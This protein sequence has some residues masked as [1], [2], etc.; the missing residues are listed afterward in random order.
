MFCL[1]LYNEWKIIQLI[2]M[3]L[4]VEALA[5]LICINHGKEKC[6]VFDEHFH[7]IFL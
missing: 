6:Q 3:L 1:F 7:S 5:D 4:Y 2:L